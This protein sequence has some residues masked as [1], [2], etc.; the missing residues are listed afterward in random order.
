MT[1]TKKRLLCK[2]RH[3][4]HLHKDHRLHRNSLDEQKKV[5]HEEEKVKNKG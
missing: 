3:V 1:R 4:Q 5:V 2:L